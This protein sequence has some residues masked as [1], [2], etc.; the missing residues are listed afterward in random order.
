M[1]QTKTQLPQKT[2]SASSLKDTFNKLSQMITEIISTAVGNSYTT[3]TN[4]FATLITHQI[5]ISNSGISID[6]VQQLKNIFLDVIQTIVWS[7]VPK[8]WGK[9]FGTAENGNLIKKDD[10][11]II[12]STVC[13]K[14][15]V[16]FPL[17][18]EIT[19]FN[20]LSCDF[21]N[22]TFI[23]TKEMQYNILTEEF[24]KP[25]VVEVEKIVEVPQPYNANLYHWYYCYGGKKQLCDVLINNKQK[26]FIAENGDVL[27]NNIEG[28]KIY[29]FV[30]WDFNSDTLEELHSILNNDGFEAD[31]DDTQSFLCVEG[32]DE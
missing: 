32:S 6:D 19:G 5:Q 26:L 15:K 24:E 30:G 29:S 2:E 12:L 10:L 17:N 25:P 20:T 18:K 21:W 22:F 31:F 4:Y 7:V 11:K 16:V 9:D 13:D 23:A 3:V 28:F 1:E 14:E 27:S 8:E